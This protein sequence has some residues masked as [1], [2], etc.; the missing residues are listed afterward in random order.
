MLDKLSKFEV[1]YKEIEE[2]LSLPEISSNVEKSSKLA[3]ELADLKDPVTLARLYRQVLK[4]TEDLRGVLKEKHDRDFLEL[5]KIEE[6]DLEARKQELTVQIKKYLAGDD[7]D[8]GRD[9]IV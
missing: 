5:A 3:K 9:I 6:N 7:K 1:R 8:A 2:Q 4:E